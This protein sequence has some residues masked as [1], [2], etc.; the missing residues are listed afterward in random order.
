VGVFL[1]LLAL[2]AAV[3]PGSTTSSQMSEIQLMEDIPFPTSWDVKNRV[4]NGD[5]LPTSTG[6]EFLPSTGFDDSLM[7][8]F[9]DG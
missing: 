7:S 2:V 3:P 8:F 5:K 9:E 6:A 4:N 1:V